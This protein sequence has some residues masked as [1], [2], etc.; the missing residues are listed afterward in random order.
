MSTLPSLDCPDSAG[1]MG[2]RLRE[3]LMSDV[4]VC[5]SFVLFGSGVEMETCSNYKGLSDPHD[6]R[7]EIHRR[8][9]NI[10]VDGKNVKE[11][12]QILINDDKE[13]SEGRR[14]DEDDMDTAYDADQNEEFLIHQPDL[15]PESNGREEDE[16]PN[17]DDPNALKDFLEEFPA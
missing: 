4:C 13:T 1:E 14:T 9:T 3:R 11:L 7:F 10:N 12:I 15:E 5:W 2:D 8:A 6:L 16:A 17:L